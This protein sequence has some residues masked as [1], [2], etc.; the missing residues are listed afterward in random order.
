MPYCLNYCWL[1]QS[2]VLPLGIRC[3]I[4]SFV[5]DMK[6][7]IVLAINNSHFEFELN[8]TVD[9][10]DNTLCYIA[11]M[12]INWPLK[13]RLKRVEPKRSTF[14]DFRGVLTRR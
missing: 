8:E 6:L 2:C 13:G 4:F 5:Q 7:L 14:G 10:P 1:S 12:S 11:D 3:V 9:V